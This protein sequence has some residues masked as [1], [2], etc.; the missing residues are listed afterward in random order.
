AYAFTDYRS[1]GQTLPY[2]IINVASPPTG[3]LTLF[4]L[5]VAL[6]RSAGRKTIRLL[7]DFDDDLFKAAHDP[8][9]LQE[10]D[11]LIR[12]TQQHYKGVVRTSGRRTDLGK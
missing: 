6:S 11:R 2:V 3:K 7:R 10:D 9:L 12:K 1:Q 4:N 5:Y 8:Q